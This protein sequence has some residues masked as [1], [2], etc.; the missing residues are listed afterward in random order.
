MTASLLAEQTLNGLQ[1]GLLIFLVSAG[2][3]L[4]LGIMNML[5]LTHGAFYTLG[6]YVGASSYTATGSFLLAAVAAVAAVAAI[7]LLAERAVIRHLYSRSHLD[8]LLGTFGLLLFLTELSRIVWGTGAQMIESPPALGLTVELLPGLHYPL[9]RLIVMAI[10]V[11]ASAGMYY[12]IQHTRVG[13]RI[14]A[15]ASN[16][17]MVSAVG[18]DVDRVF[19]MVF[20]AGAALAALAGIMMAPLIAV[21]TSMGDTATVLCFVIIAIGGLGSIRG[22]FIAALLVGLIDTFGRALLPMLLGYTVGPPLAA[23]FIYLFMALVLLVRP[24]GLVRAQ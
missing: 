19:L 12:V 17:T 7:A 14:R 20:L 10:A 6:A 4:V 18:V 9:Y 21:D 15:C 8:Q 24:G 5:N 23:M 1:F 13:M 2:L 22:A 11:A 3:T 16:Q